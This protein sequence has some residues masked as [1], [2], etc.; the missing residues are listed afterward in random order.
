MDQCRARQERHSAPG[1]VRATSKALSEVSSW[2][3][4]R[5]SISSG[6]G[7]GILDC[8]GGS[9]QAHRELEL[10]LAA[11]AGDLCLPQQRDEGES[12]TS[13]EDG[14]KLSPDGSCA[15]P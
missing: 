4:P 3:W 14:D 9:W 2:L 1:M 15:A 11:Q 8:L 13:P 7:G 10:S 6:H 5:F 12:P